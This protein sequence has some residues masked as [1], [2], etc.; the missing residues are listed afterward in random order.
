MSRDT[1]RDIALAA[2]GALLIALSP[3]T[4]NELG[5]SLGIGVAVAGLWLLA[6]IRRRRGLASTPEPA[7]EGALALGD[8]LPW[9]G[10]AALW[11]LA[12]WPTIRWL[13]DQW[14]ASLWSN[15]HGIFMPFIIG[16][17]AWTILRN[18]PVG[19]RQSSTLGFW[20]L[21]VGLSLSF[22][23]ALLETRYLGMLG[24]LI[25]LPGLS[26]LAFGAR[27]TRLLGVPMVLSLLMTPVP[28]TLSTHLYLRYATAWAVEPLLRGLGLPVFREDTVM[29]M[30]SGV[31]VVADACSGFATLYAS[32]AV[33]LVLVFLVRKPSQRILILLAAP[34]LAIGANIVR[35]LALILIAHYGGR[36]TLDTPLHEA[37]GV[38]AFA[39]VLLALFALSRERTHT[40]MA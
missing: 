37:T 2:A 1:L 19:T 27:R 5:P 11:A 10:V 25:T 6:R 7:P 26:L 36:W 18:D 13:Y 9:L 20:P 28:V 15:E 4:P 17:L 16:Y 33:A 32:L 30:S 24:M 21:G 31:F 3:L 8:L 23:D 14:T 38:A 22:L 12:F 34:I 40:E 29:H 39:I 35:V